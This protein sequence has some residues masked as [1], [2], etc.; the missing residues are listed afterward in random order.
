MSRLGIVRVPDRGIEGC[1][2]EKGVGIGVCKMWIS[3]T[4]IAALGDHGKSLLTL[5]S[6]D[7]IDTPLSSLPMHVLRAIA[8]TRLRFTQCIS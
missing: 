4:C 3:Q 2:V 5:I 1:K 6:S 7:V 8:L